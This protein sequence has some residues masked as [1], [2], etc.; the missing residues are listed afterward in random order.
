MRRTRFALWLNDS[1]IA[2][3]CFALAFFWLGSITFFP[4]SA[5]AAPANMLLLWE[6]ASPPTGWSFVSTYNGRFARGE[7]EANVGL[8][9]GTAS[10]VISVAS[11]TVASISDTSSNGGLNLTARS[12]SGHTHAITGQS[13]TVTSTAGTWPPAYRSLRVIKP[14]ANGMSGTVPAGAIAMFDDSPGMPGSNWTQYTDINGRML[15]LD[16]SIAPTNGGNDTKSFTVTWGALG[17][18]SGNQNT[19]TGGGN[20]GAATTHT[21]TAPAQTVI[22]D[23]TLPIHVQPVF[24][25]A[26]VDTVVP[27]GML[28]LFDGTLGAGWQVQSAS[29]GTYF[30][31]FLRGAAAYSAACASTCANTFN[32]PVATSGATGNSGTTTAQSA[33]DGNLAGP[34]HTHTENMNFTAGTANVPQYVN[35][36]IAK[37]I[38]F[39]ANSYRWWYDNDNQNVATAWGTPAIAEATPISTIPAPSDPP[40]PTDEL[41]LRTNMIVSGPLLPVSTMQ[42]KLQFK[43]GTDQSCATGSWTDVGAGGS[44]TIWRFATSGVTD[45]TT[46][47]AT[48][49]SPGSDVLELYSKSNPTAVNP[50]AT[51]VNG[52]TIEY[53]FHIEDNGAPGATMY[54]FRLVESSGF[55]LAAYSVCPTLTTAPDTGSL[56]RHGNFFENESERGF[57]WAN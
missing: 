30:Q 47:T 24:A 48:K 14:T 49:L 10:V 55:L 42:F 3:L 8:T 54:S 15:M 29:G 39:T 26:T 52:Q 9:G 27:P 34:S 16:S 31:N 40:I 35:L 5:N 23:A 41:R 56:L 46:L 50:A 20:F 53:D 33:T 45:N 2:A 21:H 22:T 6:S 18:A 11:T 13:T 19:G 37:K 32:Q 38:G 36:V 28:T 51:T 44:G 1:L 17:A 4:K 25:K 43:Q 12:A 7:S 57:F